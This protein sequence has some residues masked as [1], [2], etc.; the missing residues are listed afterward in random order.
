M[1]K[2]L[3]IILA[4]PCLLLSMSIAGIA[5]AGGDAGALVRDAKKAYAARD[6]VR[7]AQLF[8]KAY[9]ADP[10]PALRVNAAQAWRFAGDL[11]RAA[12]AYAQALAAR[13]SGALGAS[14]RKF[15]RDKL[16]EIEKSTG[17]LR[18]DEPR[19]GKLSVAHIERAP[20]PAV[21]HL[22]P[23]SHEIRIEQPDGRSVTRTVEL[24][25]SETST[26]SVVSD[27]PP[28]AP[29]AAPAPTP[30]PT[31]EPA[32][33][34]PKPPESGL[35][36]VRIAGW[37]TLAVGV[38]LG[39]VTGYLGYRT[40]DALDRWEESLAIGAPDNAAYDEATTMKTATNVTLAVAIAAGAAGI[41]MLVIP[42]GDDDDDARI[43]LGPT[44]ARWTAAF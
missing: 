28:P 29:G 40:L 36:A 11:P 2:H 15:V 18:I 25:A 39:G 32:P 12:D 42:L 19:G 22:M 7:A 43:E 37:T 20:I 44:G 24:E 14:D 23:G 38:A 30:T 17:K 13:G 1:N 8:E 34:Q 27:A 26:L 5:A 33:A 4:V 10:V 16:A 3:T 21:V 35:P 9:A 31:K 6:Y 41:L